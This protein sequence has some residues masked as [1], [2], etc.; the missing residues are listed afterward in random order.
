MKIMEFVLYEFDVTST[1]GLD[2][3]ESLN[4]QNME[5]V[6]E[7]YE[8]FSGFF[9]L[10]ECK[11]ALSFNK[12]DIQN[13]A[14]WLVDEGEKERS[15]RT[16]VVKQTTLLAQAEISSDISSKTLKNNSEILVKEGSIVAPINV[17]SNIWTMNKDQVALYTEFGIKIFS[18]H[19]KDV[20]E[21]DS[22][23][24]SLLQ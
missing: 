18:K 7:L 14:Q 5:I 13:A 10:N 4:T 9:S 12:D 1:Q 8:S 6:Q 2:V 20:K 19:Q 24:N 22:G 21:L 17:S 16:V 15:K 23:L 3:S 11:R